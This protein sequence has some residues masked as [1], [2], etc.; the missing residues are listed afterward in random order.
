MYAK[1]I[2][3]LTVFLFE[4]PQQADSHKE[5]CMYLLTELFKINRQTKKL[6]IIKW[7]WIAPSKTFLPVGFCLLSPSGRM[8]LSAKNQQLM[9]SYPSSITLYYPS[10]LIMP[11]VKYYSFLARTL[12]E[13]FQKPYL[14]TQIIDPGNSIIASC[15]LHVAVFA[16]TNQDINS[17]R[18]K[19]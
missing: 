7:T 19:L 10:L 16:R 9:I 11:A 18:I 8:L 2:V 1:A 5:S 15:I 17:F 3:T 6:L 12:L 13:G 14:Q 4:K